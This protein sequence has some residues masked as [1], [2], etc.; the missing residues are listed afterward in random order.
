MRKDLVKKE[1][2][3]QI[4]AEKTYYMMPAVDVYEN[5]KEI[6][7]IADMPGVKKENLNIRLEKDE[8]TIE[9]RR[10]SFTEGTPLNAEWPECTYRR[11]FTI[12]QS[13]DI[14]KVEAELKNGVLTIHLPK[15]ETVQPKQIPV[16]AE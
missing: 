4:Q 8:L 10:E 2:T 1:G 7:L 13:I 11:S 15:P 3:E 12:N 9:G 14:D 5:D 16:R 6:L